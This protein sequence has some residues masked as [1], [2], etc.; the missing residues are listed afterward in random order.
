M[1]R[2]HR[3]MHLVLWLLLAPAVFAIV[4]LAVMYR[5]ADPVNDLLPDLLIEEAS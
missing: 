2:A 4:M 1:K 5:P 3:K